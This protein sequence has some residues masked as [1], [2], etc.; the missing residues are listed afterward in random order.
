MYRVDLRR[1]LADALVSDP[2]PEPGPGDRLAAV[3]VPIVEPA[4]ETADAAIVFTR[5]T[6]HLSRHAGE[7]SFPGGIRH[8][9]DADLRATAL[10][11]SEEELALAPSAVEV[12]GALPAVHTFVSSIL[13]VPFVGLLRGRPAF[14]PDA[15]E[16]AE[17]LEYGLTS[18]ID[19]ERTVEFRRQEGVYRGYA[20]EMGPHTIWGATARILHDLLELVRAEPRARELRV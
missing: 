15:G 4:D 14:R 18:L 13:V 3:L 11:E 12:L 8:E 2:R 9:D 19:A 5:R 1:H 10:R 6:E 16:I 17:V 7:I 20:Y